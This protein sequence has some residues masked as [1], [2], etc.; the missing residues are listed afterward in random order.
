MGDRDL[1]STAYIALGS[2]LGDRSA[3]IRQSLEALG[4][5]QGLRVVRVSTWHETAAAGGPAGQGPYLNGAARLETL[6]EP[7]ALLRRM[8]AVEAALGRVRAERWGPRTIDLDL[9]LY[10]D[11]VIDTPELTLPHPRL[12]ERSFVLAPLAEIAG[13]VRHPVLGR[14]MAELLVALT[15][16]D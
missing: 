10:E 12:H 1:W 6:L 8:H 4:R 14:T 3:R 11:R 16:K 7:V 5:E 13:D 9:L 15:D 2:N